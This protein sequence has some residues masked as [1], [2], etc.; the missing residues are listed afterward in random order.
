MGVVNA[1]VDNTDFDSLAHVLE[2]LVDIVDA[3]HG[4]GVIQLLGG[5]GLVLLDLGLANGNDL[6]RPDAF[7]TG[8]VARS[9][10]LWPDSTS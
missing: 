9:S 7:D 3:G 10:P 2:R 1:S 6:D 5:W 8:I 4:V